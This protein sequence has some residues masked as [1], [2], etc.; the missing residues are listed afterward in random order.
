MRVCQDDVVNTG[1]LGSIAKSVR[2][3]SGIKIKD[4][5]SEHRIGTTVVSEFER[6]GKIP[7]AGRI[8][9]T[10][11]KAYRRPE[12]ALCRVAPGETVGGGRDSYV[13]GPGERDPLRGLRVSG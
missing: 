4:W 6:L 3:H 2:E 1:E 8:R 5:A 7:P 12:L 13:D 9:R 11:E 10:L